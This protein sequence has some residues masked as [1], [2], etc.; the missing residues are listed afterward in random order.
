M[1]ANPVASFDYL[2]GAGEQR[3]RDFEAEVLCRLEIDDQLEP[4]RLDNRQVGWRVAFEYA[5]GIGS[6]YS[7]EFIAISVVTH[8][9]AG[10]DE[11]APFV[12]C[13]NPVTGR[14]RDE[15][16]TDDLEKL[17]CP[18]NN[19]RDVALCHGRKRLI[20]L[21]F[22]ADAE[23]E[24][25]LSDGL[26]CRLHF[27]N[28]KRRAGGIRVRHKGNRAGFRQEFAHE[29]ET[30]WSK[31]APDHEHAGGIAAWP[32][33]AGDEA[34]LDRVEPAGEHDGNSRSRRSCRYGRG[35]G[36]GDQNRHLLANEFGRK[37][38]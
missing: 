28:L 26:R 32:V 17:S 25:R 10:S 24:Q 29:F 34:K 19:R 6:C 15:L 30:F 5:A 18:V 37:P 20:D 16:L 21:F 38:R 3:R 35:P 12:E 27:P 4:D 36:G 14:E 31:F 11:F 1:L 33:E 8:Q 2:V 13:R 22:G 7:P 23:N 9:A